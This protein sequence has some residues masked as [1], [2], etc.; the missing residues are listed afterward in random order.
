MRHTVCLQAIKNVVCGISGGVDSAVSALLLKKKGYEVI[1]LFMRNWDVANEK[2]VCMADKDM[3]D[4]QLVC[5][6]IGIPFL[7][8][9]FVKEYWNEVF[10]SF[11][12]DLRAGLTPNPD[13]LCNK[14][15]KFGALHDYAINKLG[16]DAVATGHY[17]RTS[18]GEDLESIDERKGV[19][20]LQAVDR[21]KCQTLFLSQISQKALQQAI[22]PVGS[23]P[24]IVVKM[25]AKEAGL[26]KISQKKESVGICFIGKRHFP[27]LIKDY[28]EP[29]PGNIVHI[30]T[31]EILGEHKGLHN[32]TFGQ[33]AHIPGKT[34]RMFVAKKD[35]QTNELV[36]APGTDHPS[37]FYKTLFTEPAHWINKPPRELVQ[38]AMCDVDFKVQ[39]GERADVKS[40][41]TLSGAN[42][43][44]VSL[45]HPLRAVSPGQYAVFYRGDVCLGSAK[46][47]KQGP[48]V[49]DLK[50]LR[51]NQY[52]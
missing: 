37:L 34:I 29:Q 40:T 17:A 27:D 6:H 43:L 31:G 50:S 48:S 42:C 4:A 52:A 2:G 39:H 35:R 24:K 46:I 8:V 23:I 9:N 16:A 18:V 1:G 44:T 26:E 12:S 25:I 5:Q 11:I 32:W 13:V 49:Y 10:S 7:E 33:R 3:E 28:I 20:L 45:E 15:I 30:E 22:F 14:Y 21:V 47:I 19:D 41:L 38:I 36:V 51:Q